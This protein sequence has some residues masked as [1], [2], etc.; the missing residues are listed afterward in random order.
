MMRLCLGKGSCQYHSQRCHR[1]GCFELYYKYIMANGVESYKIKVAMFVL[2]F[3]PTLRTI[4]TIILVMMSGRSPTVIQ[5][6]TEVVRRT[7]GI[8]MLSLWL[9]GRDV[10]VSSC[11]Y[12][13]H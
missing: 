13:F 10:T 8:I 11:R 4:D 1:T 7:S 3:P 2:L 12:V 5:E 6:I 9:F